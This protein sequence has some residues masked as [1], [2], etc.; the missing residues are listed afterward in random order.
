MKQ[1]IINKF[2]EKILQYANNTEL[3][4]SKEVP[5]YIK[6]ILEFNFYSEVFYLC[7]LVSILLVGALIF[8]LGLRVFI[9]S[10]EGIEEIV[11]TCIIVIGGL[12]SFC[13]IMALAL[14]G[15]DSVEKI[16]KIKTAPRVFII[17]YVKGG[18]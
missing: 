10:K 17:D 18:K 6:E 8:Y 1:E 14:G 12:I 16:I 5:I 15:F 11:S 3:F 13:S 2:M 4:L 9:K 7:Y